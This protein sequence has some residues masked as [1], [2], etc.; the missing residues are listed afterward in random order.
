M[1]QFL[2]VLCTT[3]SGDTETRL[4]NVADISNVKPNPKRGDRHCKSLI[5]LRSNDEFPIWCTET[6]EEIEI[7]LHHLGTEIVPHG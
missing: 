1:A 6:L 4:V 5:S 3:V 2:K 7:A